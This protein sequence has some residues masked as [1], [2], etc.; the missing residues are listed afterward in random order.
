M[1]PIN[2][3]I[4]D[5]FSSLAD[6]TRLKIII[7][8]SKKPMTVNEIYEAVGKEKLSL[9]AISHQLKQLHNLDIVV[10]EKKGREKIFSLSDS[11]CWCILKNA[12]DHFEGKTE[13]KECCKI[14]EERR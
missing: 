3:K 11:F 7:S 1:K 9:S 10:S 13:C 4:L 2:K 8:L 6:E 12:F 5:F 14:K